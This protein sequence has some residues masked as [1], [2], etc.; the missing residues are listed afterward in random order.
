[1]N[2]TRV[3]LILECECTFHLI[4][5]IIIIIIIIVLFFHAPS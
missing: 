4:I 3:F 2:S 5:I 1:M